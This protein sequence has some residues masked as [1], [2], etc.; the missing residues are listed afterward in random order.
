M[1][2]KCADLYFRCILE[3]M[4]QLL[5]DSYRRLRAVRVR[6][7][8]LKHHINFTFVKDAAE[9]VGSGLVERVRAHLQVPVHYI[10]EVLVLDTRWFGRGVGQGARD[11]QHT[12]PA[13]GRNWRF[14]Q[15]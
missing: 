2:V 1:Y 3:E 11:L 13:G 14:G 9:L 8:L 12:G 4:V 10:A 5:G 15:R 7:R 6:Q